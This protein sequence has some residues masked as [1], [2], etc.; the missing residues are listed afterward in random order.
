MMGH[1]VEAK[2]TWVIWTKTGR[3]PKYYH[4]TRDAAECEARRLAEANP[5]KKFIVMQMVGKYSFQGEPA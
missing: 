1:H 3:R 2:D 4:Y 5:G